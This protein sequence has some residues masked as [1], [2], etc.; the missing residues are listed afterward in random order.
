MGEWLIYY[1]HYDNKNGGTIIEGC[2][3]SVLPPHVPASHLHL[4]RFHAISTASSM[5]P[6]SLRG[7]APSLAS[8][9][10]DSPGIHLDA[11]TRASVMMVRRTTSACGDF[12]NAELGSGVRALEPIPVR[13]S[14]PEPKLMHSTG[15][16]LKPH[17]RAAERGSST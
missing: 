6:R 7:K 11:H 2:T 8:T 9:A 17:T 16:P 5:Y 13:C 15:P 1:Y 12:F 14:N 3:N 10:R 4:M